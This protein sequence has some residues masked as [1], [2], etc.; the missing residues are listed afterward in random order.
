MTDV[1]TDAVRRYVC[2]EHAGVVEAVRACA[3]ASASAGTSDGRSDTSAVRRGTEAC[4]RRH[5]VWGQLPRVLAGCV[6]QTETRLRASP[7]AAAP[8]VTSTATGVVLRATLDGGRLVVSI[9]ALT[10]ERGGDGPT[11]RPRGGTGE[12]VRVEWRQ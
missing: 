9:E 2:S 12:V 6:E 5:D 11:L 10:V 7:V 3:E 4:L 8:Y 1:D